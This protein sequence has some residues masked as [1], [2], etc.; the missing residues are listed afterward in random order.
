MSEK[1]IFTDISE[2]IIAENLIKYVFYDKRPELSPAIWQDAEILIRYY[3]R[4]VWAIS[5]EQRELGE[6]AIALYAACYIIE[7]LSTTDISKIVGEYLLGGGKISLAKLLRDKLHADIYDLITIQEKR[8][9]TKN[10]LV[11]G[12]Y[13]TFDREKYDKIFKHLGWIDFDDA[14][15]DLITEKIYCGSGSYSFDNDILYFLGATDEFRNYDKWFYI[16][17]FLLLT[18]RSFDV[19]YLAGDILNIIWMTVDPKDEET[20]QWFCDQVFEIFWPRVG[21]IKVL[22]GKK[23]MNDLNED[24]KKIL[25][26]SI[27]W[28]KSL[29]DLRERL[30]KLPKKFELNV[31]NLDEKAFGNAMRKLK[32]AVK[33]EDASDEEIGNLIARVADTSWEPEDAAKFEKYVLQE[34]IPII[35]NKKVLAF[36]KHAVMH[37]VKTGETV[38]RERKVIAGIREHLKNWPE[39]ISPSE[40]PEFL[41]EIKL[42]YIVGAVYERDDPYYEYASS[43]WRMSLG[44]VA[45]GKKCH[46]MII[47]PELSRKYYD[48]ISKSGDFT[49]ESEVP[50]QYGREVFTRKQ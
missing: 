25:N 35:E 4:D 8:I 21:D 30:P 39:Y 16:C 46:V 33:R 11:S 44:L 14:A 32:K 22:T 1:Q 15:F 42:E 34:A 50:N 38:E 31:G 40:N 28:L 7:H 37:A 48:L 47:D 45:D 27:G 2:K 12:E 5:D 18:T 20:N 6:I 17:K 43:P 49:C 10:D 29:P 23:E 24:E 3:K 9:V 41:S 13:N 36:A 26:D 19:F